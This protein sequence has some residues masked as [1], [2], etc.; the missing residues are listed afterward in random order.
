MRPQFSTQST[1]IRVWRS[2]ATNILVISNF[3]SGQVDSGKQV[4]AIYTDSLSAF[5][6]LDQLYF[7]SNFLIRDYFITPHVSVYPAIG[8]PNVLL[9]SNC[10]T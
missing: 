8:Y 2:T 7:R 5:D 9:L 10:F 1:W 3:I 6:R 4:D